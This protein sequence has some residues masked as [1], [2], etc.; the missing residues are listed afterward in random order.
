MLNKLLKENMYI[1][2]IFSKSALQHIKHW[3][4][5]FL[6]LR[7]I[8]NKSGIIYGD[9]GLLAIDL[10]SDNPEY[11]KSKA[12]IR[13]DRNSKFFVEGRIAIRPTSFLR[14]HKNAVLKIEKN[15]LFTQNTQLF[16]F[17]EIT[18][19][20]GTTIGHSSI[21]RDG[22]AH[23]ILDNNNTILN[24]K[25]NF[26]HIGRNC[27]ICANAIILKGVTIGDNAIIA[28]GAVVTKD[29]P[30][31]SIV[32]GNPAKIVKENINWRA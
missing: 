11:N 16:C 2:K 26:I 17:N 20:E 3:F 12:V 18:I 25:N 1:N 21:I 23:E 19:G 14:I 24:N 4:L 7:L 27:W 5:R 31:G 30:T 9:D 22:D 32:A 6:Y 10:D 8:G 29:V 15:V 28:A 13:L